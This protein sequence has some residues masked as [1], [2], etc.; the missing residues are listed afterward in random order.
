MAGQL[1]RHGPR[2]AG[3]GVLASF[4]GPARAVQCSK[5]LNVRARAL[6]LP[7]RA[8]IHTGECE[9][10][11]DRLA[12]ITLHLAARVVT[13]AGA[14]EILTTST[15]RDLVNGSGLTFRDRG[16]HSMKGFDGQ[17]QVLAVDQ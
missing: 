17:I 8:G 7:I 15:V 11:G 5:Q 14:G 1:H 12:G 2:Y 3:D 13:L 9:V 4:D 6:G 16:A 10:R